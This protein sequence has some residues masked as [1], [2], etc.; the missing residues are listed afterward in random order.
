M[1]HIPSCSRQAAGSL[2]PGRDDPGPLPVPAMTAEAP[3]AGPDLKGLL[4]EQLRRLAADLGEA[5]Y[6]GDQLFSW[7]HGRGETRL[8]SMSNL[9]LRLRRALAEAGA[10]VSRLELIDRRDSAAGMAV[11]FIFG[12][13]GGGQFESV[14]ILDGRRRTLCL[15]SQVGCALD[16][17]FCATGRMGFVRN[18]TAAQI[19]DQLLQVHAA[20]GEE[21]RITN[22]VMMGMGEPLLNYDA[23][24]TALRLIRRA[25]GPS[26]G[27][28][29]IT[30]ST[31]GYLPGIRRLAEDDLNVG[32]AISLNATTDEVRE[33]L[34]PIN[35]RWPIADLLAAA[36]HYFDR[37]GRR[38]TF[39]YV[40]LRGVTDTGAD[41]ERLARLTAEVP[42]K[43]NL[44]P[45]NEL[46][47]GGPGEPVFHRPE[48][49]RIRAFRSRLESLTSR[50]V[51]LRESRGRDIDAA[52]GQLYRGP[53]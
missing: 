39:E 52:C 9:P 53:G 31:A 22:I 4:P 42:C 43:I 27:G 40:L 6:R 19:V 51:R 20:A 41:A 28:R 15:S 25:E 23:V 49:A 16:C 24:T 1:L 29:R 14:L 5:P 46:S 50:T 34:M 33:R 36:R 7:I 3:A 32:L 48:R 21:G 45:Y 8:E 38:V 30:V 17:R 35:R 18:L 26:V 13:G 47:P 11:K 12:D 44:I 10:R 37:Q 2:Q